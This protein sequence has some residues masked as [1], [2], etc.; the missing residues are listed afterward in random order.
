MRWPI[1]SWGARAR[2]LPGDQQVATSRPTALRGEHPSGSISGKGADP[3][4][5]RAGPNPRSPQPSELDSG[6]PDT[7]CHKQILR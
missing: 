1:G 4:F 6:M 3:R 2:S 7:Y 5:R